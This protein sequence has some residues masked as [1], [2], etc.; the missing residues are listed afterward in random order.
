MRRTSS[1]VDFHDLINKLTSTQIH[2]F[3]SFMLVGSF[4][5]LNN[6]LG[7]FFT[8]RMACLYRNIKNLFLSLYYYLIN[9]VNLNTL[10]ANFIIKTPH[11][12]PLNIHPISL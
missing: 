5:D 10:K 4:L 9:I 8:S 12:A 11:S 7:I 6:I 2:S 3:T 1:L